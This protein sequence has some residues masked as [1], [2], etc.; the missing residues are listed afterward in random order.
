MNEA[1]DACLFENLWKTLSSLEENSDSVK[2]VVDAVKSPS[3]LQAL[4]ESILETLSLTFKTATLSYVLTSVKIASAEELKGFSVVE[5]V[6]G[7]KVVFVDNAENTKRD[8]GQHT[9]GTLDYGSVRSLIGRKF[10]V[11]VE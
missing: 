7:D 9:D 8:K 2:C 11:A 5:S 10:D 3:A 6:D 1:K 4:R